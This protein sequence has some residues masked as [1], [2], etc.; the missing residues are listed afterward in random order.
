MSAT[1]QSTNDCV[2]AAL[3]EAVS[4]C[5]KDLVVKTIATMRM[6]KVFIVRLESPPFFLVDAVL[7]IQAELRPKLPSDQ[8]LEA[9]LRGSN[10]VQLAD[11]SLLEGL[12]KLSTH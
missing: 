10:S 6:Q 5:A 8:M 11:G 1:G 9:V 4:S 3:L 12:K 2:P 7:T